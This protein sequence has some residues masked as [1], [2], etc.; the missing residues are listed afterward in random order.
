[1]DMTGV[2]V[3]DELF[4]YDVNGSRVGQPPGGWPGTVAKVGRKYFIVK[5]NGHR[6]TQFLL[7]NGRDSDGLRY[8]E[9]PEQAALGRRRQ[10]AVEVLRARGISIGEARGLT[11]EQ[12]E[13]LAALV[14]TFN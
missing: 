2:K 11:L 8:V 6:A 12:I 7:E 4:V 1:M 13:Q 3:D 9:T 5:Y 10:L 14:R